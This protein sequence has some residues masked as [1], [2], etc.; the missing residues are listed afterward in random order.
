MQKYNKVFSHMKFHHIVV[1][2]E[3][4][5]NETRVALTPHSVSLLV[6]R[7]HTV[8]VENDAGVNAGFN[9]Q[10]YIDVGATIIDLYDAGIPANSFIVRVLRPSKER[11]LFENSLIHEN[12]AILGFLFPFYP[13][14][15]IDM[16]QTLGVTTLSL[17]L[18]KSL[19]IDDPKNAQ[20]AMS[21][22]AG[23]LAFESAI[24][25]YQ[26]DAPL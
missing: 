26:G 8:L 16:W 17:D 2:K 21:R 10:H 11:Q 23:R 9:N 3:S 12:T 22:I 1:L 13:D 20:A 15:H 18:F 14:N 6:K 7:G 24:Q 5:Q 4:H 25:H 19:S